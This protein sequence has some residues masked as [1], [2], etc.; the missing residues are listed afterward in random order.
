MTKEV[1]PTAADL[2]AEV[3]QSLYE[4]QYGEAES[5]C[6]PRNILLRPLALPEVV[7]IKAQREAEEAYRLLWG[8]DW[9]GEARA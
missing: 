2:E 8:A 9:L 3:T 4:Q 6:V 7:N 1:Q 5:L